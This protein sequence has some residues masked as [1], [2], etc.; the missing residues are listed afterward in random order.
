MN[1]I[2]G[3]T[4]Y[5]GGE[6]CRRLVAVGRPV[7]ALVRETADPARVTALQGLGVELVRG[8]LKDPE[9]LAR[10]CEGVA[11]VV[12][13]A[14][15][16]LSRQPGDSIEA[17]DLQGQKDLVDTAAAAG[18]ERFIY[19]SVAGYLPASEPF[20]AAKRAVED[21]V[22][23]SGMTYTNLRP[24]SFM[25]VWLGPAAGV[26][27]EA[28][29]ASVVG[30][31]DVPSSWISLGDVAEFAVRALD[32]PAAANRDL[33]LG[34]PE[35]LTAL[36]AIRIFEELIGRPFEVQ[37]IPLEVLEAQAAQAHDPYERTLARLMIS[38][39][40]LPGVI[41]ME[42][43]ARAFAVRLTSVRDYAARALTPAGG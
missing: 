35:A 23:N 30:A 40:T 21:H 25:E 41:P 12:S 18:V 27:L 3:A 13:T 15:T 10:A 24:G 19:V 34:G 36:A 6:I 8:D 2:V 26:D 43:T 42:A 29:R 4:G 1:L 37:H 7:R 16:T 39:G 14:A 28:G 32:H 9:S 38:V 22:R 20:L 31:G 17:T 33:E 5:L 11:A